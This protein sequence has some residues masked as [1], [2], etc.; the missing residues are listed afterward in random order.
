MTMVYLSINGLAYLIGIP[1]FLVDDI[2]DPDSLPDH[3]Y[4]SDGTVKNPVLS[5]QNA[6]I[7]GS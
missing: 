1:D 6:T 3:I 5:V 2:S 7:S 4:C